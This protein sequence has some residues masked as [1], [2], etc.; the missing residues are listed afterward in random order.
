MIEELELP[1]EAPSPEFSRNRALPVCL[2][3]WRE[4]PYRLV[5]L[6]DMLRFYAEHFCRASGILGQMYSKIQQGFNLADS[7]WGVIGGELGLLEKHCDNL[8]L[9][10]TGSQIKRI[11]TLLDDGHGNVP[12]EYFGQQMIEVHTRL[13]DELA[14]H[15][16]LN[17]VPSRVR[18]YEPREVL[19]GLEVDARF[20]STAY[21]IAEAG[22]CYALYRSTACVFHLMRV[23]EIGL[24]VFADR[25]GVP[26]DRQ[27]WHN[28]I[29]GIE[30]AVRGMSSDPARPADWK[31]QQ[32][33]FSGAA[34]QFMFFKDAW[35][36]YV[37]HGRDKCTEG[38]AE[39]ILNSTQAFM[40]TLATRLRE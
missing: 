19:F 17:V 22:K 26:S 18:F 36:N 31:D 25:F 1:V 39:K 37:T 12:V 10:I 21:D 24:R 9:V 5:S 3:P 13:V 32:E 27:N 7:S 40:Q 8:G 28:I 20:P 34:T 16:F 30:K 35:R 4:N 15:T 38:E 6:W 11:K 29:E 33:F 23:L 14:S 2:P